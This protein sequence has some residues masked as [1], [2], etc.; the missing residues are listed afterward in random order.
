MPGLTLSDTQLLILSAAAQRDD[1]RIVPP[2]RLRG[3]AGQ[4]VL[5]ALLGKALIEEIPPSEV[6]RAAFDP[7]SAE[8]TAYRI[9]IGGLS[10]IGLETDEQ[11]DSV[12]AIGIEAGARA[13]LYRQQRMEPSAVEN[14]RIVVQPARAPLPLHLYRRGSAWHAFLWC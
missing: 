6:E 10:A 5:A 13:R 8:Q 7:D 12:T 14:R 3:G 2:V 9:S 11:R 1:L 4:K